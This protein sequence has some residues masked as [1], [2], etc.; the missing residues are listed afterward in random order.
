MKMVGRIK[1]QRKLRELYD[2]AESEFVVVY[3]R[4][5]IGKTYLVR[6][7][8][9]GEFAF[10]HAGLARCGM[11]KQLQQFRSSL[12]EYGHV[13]CPRLTNWIDAFDELKTAVKKSELAR[14]VVFIDEMPWMDTPKSGFVPALENFWN[15][16]A[17]GRKDVLLVVCGSA[18][19]WIIDKVL[20]NK[21]GLHDRVTEEI[22]L[23]PFTLHECEEYATSRGLGYT[24]RMIVETYMILGGVPYYWRMLRR[25]MGPAQ[26][27]DELFFDSVGRLRRE[28]DEL[29]ASLFKRKE[30]YV[31]IVT[32]LGSKGAGMSRD[33]LVAASGLADGGRFGRYLEELEEC[34]FIRRFQAIG[35]KT[36]GA[37]YQLVDS[38][39]LFY[40]N[41]V[42]GKGKG[43]NRRW[44]DRLETPEYYNWAGRAFE[45]VCLL[46]VRNI[47]RALEIGGVRTSEYAWRGV[48]DCGRKAQI[49]L[50]IDRNDGI[51]DICEM[52]YTREP[53]VLT[54]EEWN[55]I[56]HRRKALKD[57]SSTHKALHVVMVTDL[58]MVRNAW[59]KEVMGFVSTDDLFA[60]D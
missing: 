30:P 31:T 44:T 27:F 46:H 12:K 19:S 25:G 15:G 26:D 23:A 47:K 17:S 55:R 20:K 41:F 40:L 35:M 43:E 60:S 28:F 1:E 34:G 22:A 9:D 11:M 36:K 29:Y 56:A 2:S 14:K 38:Y 7:T 5:R 18:T 6:E 16:W 58:P 39:T 24:R 50:L 10:S 59:S 42:A 51:I 33:E 8:F 37:I 3:G 53:Y 13:D 45:R 21:G 49:D 57:A 54:E 32:A 4:R 52:K 48:D